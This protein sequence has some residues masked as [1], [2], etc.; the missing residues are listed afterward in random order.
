MKKTILIVILFFGITSIASANTTGYA[1]SESVG[2]F[3]FSNVIITDTNLTGYAYNDNTGWLSFSDGT[4][5]VNTNGNLSGYAWSE[6]VGWFDFSN[7][8]V[9]NGAL[10]GYAYNDNTGWLS[11]SD[12]TNVTTTWAPPENTPAPRRITGSISM[13]MM[14]P[15]TPSTLLN[16]TAPQSGINTLISKLVSDG[17][18]TQAQA[19]LIK[20]LL[21]PTAPASPTQASNNT[22]YTRDLDLNSQGEDVLKLQQFLIS[23]GYS[24]PNGPTNFFGPQ[25]QAALANY[26][27]D[28]NI[29][30]AL[31]YFGPVTRS[32]IEN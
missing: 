3:D 21:T 12:G 27:R 16:P 32:F 6:S 17:T 20:A 23:K 13:K 7:V 18:I 19:E 8:I 11:F 5:V 22:T 25:T 26:Q 15:S 14:A 4:N 30:P 31:G 28:N 9:E 29:T 2:W 1:W 10:S 24:I